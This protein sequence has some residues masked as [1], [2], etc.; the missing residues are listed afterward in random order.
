L[1][2]SLK[3][4]KSKPYVIDI[5]VDEPTDLHDIAD[6]LQ[7]IE[8]VYNARPRKKHKGIIR[9]RIEDWSVRQTFIE[10]VLGDYVLALIDD[11][12]RNNSGVV[13]FD[14]TKQLGSMSWILQDENGLT[15]SLSR[16]A[17]SE[18][19]EAIQPLYDD[20]R[21]LN[22]WHDD[23]TWHIGVTVA[24]PHY[25]DAVRG[26]FVR[27]LTDIGWNEIDDPAQHMTAGPRETAHPAEDPLPMKTLDEVMNGAD[28][29]EA[30]ST[31][32]GNST[33]P[34]LTLQIKKLKIRIG[35]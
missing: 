3:W 16:P 2:V 10:R 4:H 31:L 17:D 8:W 20:V 1:A 34:T 18:L 25:V 11:V 15:I 32:L 30:P 35:G 6:R 22:E 24:H 21:I 27:A 29:K 14:N 13:T 12:A 19:V 28:A 33:W 26:L 9:V 23:Y 7:E 5:R